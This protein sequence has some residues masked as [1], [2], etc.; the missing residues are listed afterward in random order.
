MQKYKSLIVKNLLK[1]FHMLP[2]GLQLY[3][4]SFKA[5][6]PELYELGW[7]VEKAT[8][9][10][11][12]G[13][14]KGAYTYAISKVV[15]KKGLVVA[16]EPIEE[17]AAYLQQACCQLS[18]PVKVEQCCLSDKEGEDNLFIPVKDGKLQTG[19][20]TLNKKDQGDGN[21]R[22]VKTR[23]LDDMLRDR[24]QRVSFIK[25]DVEGHEME[26]FRGAFDILKS[27]R[28]NL[29]VEIEQCHF[30]GPIK[31]RFEFFQEN[32]YVGFFLSYY[33][34][35]K[36]LKKVDLDWFAPSPLN[37]KTQILDAV[38]NF[39]FLPK[40]SANSSHFILK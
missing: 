2:F 37:E 34:G 6:E 39:I 36:E 14:N 35:A 21:I 29:L 24:N 22:K 15:G 27:D 30:D 40:E 10:V 4:R 8:I 11:D 20:A 26:V 9:A 7:L 13:A 31:K 28:P 18:L 12:I 3:L 33:N 38:I 23:R 19:F 5:Q 17:L 16:I 25:C 1:L 32:D